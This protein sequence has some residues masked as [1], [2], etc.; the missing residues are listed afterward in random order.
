MAR[1][2]GCIL[3]VALVLWILRIPVATTVVGWL[4][5]GVTPQAQDLFTE[6]LDLSLSTWLRMLWFVLMLTVA[7]ALP[8]HYVA[9]MLVDSDR[10]GDQSVLYSTSASS[11]IGRF[12]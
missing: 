12:A 7:W 9:R 11:K 10:H 8:T 3:N 2:W 5:L 1:C 6:F 4:L